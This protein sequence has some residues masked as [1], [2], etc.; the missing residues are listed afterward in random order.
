[1]PVQ[2]DTRRLA[3]VADLAGYLP[4][5]QKGAPSGLASLG[6]DGKVPAGQLPPAAAVFSVAKSADTSRGVAAMADDPHL[7]LTGLAAGT[8]QLTAGIFSAGAGMAG[9]LGLNGAAFP[10]GA[11]SLG[12][13]QWMPYN[14]ALVAGVH[15]A[16]QNLAVANTGGTTTEVGGMLSGVLRIPSGSLSFRWQSS[17]GTHV[18]KAGS[19]L[20]LEKLG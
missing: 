6:A 11:S 3:V 12:S 15:P 2:P 9:G 19:F 20:K 14:A 1:V 4:T 13:L 17:T 10:S 16:N 8:Y 5:T 7:L 18:V